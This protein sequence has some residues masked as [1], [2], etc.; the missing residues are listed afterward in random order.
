MEGYT[1]MTAEC[2]SY[3]EKGAY[4]PYLSFDSGI[5]DDT[6]PIHV[7]KF[8]EVLTSHLASPS[9]FKSAANLV[10][11]SIHAFVPGTEIEH[12]LH[13][14]VFGTKVKHPLHRRHASF[15]EDDFAGSRKEGL[16]TDTVHHDCRQSLGPAGTFFDSDQIIDNDSLRSFLAPAFSTDGSEESRAGDDAIHTLNLTSEESMVSPFDYYK[17]GKFPFIL[18]C[19]S[20]ATVCIHFVSYHFQ[21]LTHY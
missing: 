4:N 11:F 3:S 5:N 8:E 20:D 18:Y 9:H 10:L 6:V 2:P 7:D 16:F 17:N 1:A 15:H 21:S 14:H 12:P 13:R 19:I